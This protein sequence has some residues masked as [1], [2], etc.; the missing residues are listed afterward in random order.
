MTSDVKLLAK[1]GADA[2]I[3]ATE[4]EARFPDKTPDWGTLVGWF[5]NAI[6][7]G[8]EKGIAKRVANG[9]PREARK[10]VDSEGGRHWAV[11]VLVDGPGDYILIDSLDDA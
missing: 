6:E 5:A 4:Y 2:A 7:A 8:A 1:M 11:T 3:W 9:R 10:L